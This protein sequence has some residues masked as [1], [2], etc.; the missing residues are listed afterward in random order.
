MS[1]NALHQRH[2]VS[3]E[4]TLLHALLLL[5]D[6]IVE[7][8]RRVLCPTEMDITLNKAEKWLRTVQN[9]WNLGYHA[10]LDRRTA[11]SIQPV[12][13]H[14]S[15]SLLHMKKQNDSGTSIS[16]TEMSDFV[17]DVVSAVNLMSTTNVDL[18]PPHSIS[19]YSNSLAHLDDWPSY[20]VRP[21]G[22]M[23]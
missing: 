10:H 8:C 20:K 16:A 6:S 14:A 9:Y 3:Q 22:H 2:E 18:L 11:G 21:E 4:K 15:G 23:V 12:L 19:R 17:H 7:K 1:L 13:S 5:G